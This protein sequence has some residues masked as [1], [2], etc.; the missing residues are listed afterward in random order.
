MI[1][2]ADFDD[3]VACFQRAALDDDLWPAAAKLVDECSGAMSSHVAVVHEGDWVVDEESQFG[4][5]YYRG[6]SWEEAERDFLEYWPIDPRKSR[7]L[8][9]PYGRQ[10]RNRDFFD[11]QERKTAPV[12]NEFLP[13]YGIG[14]QLLTRLEA[15]PGLD[16]VWVLSRHRTR[17]EW[18]TES[19]RLIERVSAHLIHAVAVRQELLA[20]RLLGHTLEEMLADGSPGVVYLDYRGAIAGS[21]ATAECMLRSRDALV[22]RCGQLRARH[23]DDDARLGELL[24][25]ALRRHVGGAPKGG[26]VAIRRQPCESPFAVH[27][28]PV[29]RVHAAFGT[30]RVAVLVLIVDPRM[31]L[32]IDPHQTAQLLGLT[33]AEGRVVARLAEGMSVRE[34]V[35]ASGR[36]ENTVRSHLKSALA[37]TGCSR[38]ADLV[39]L[40]FRARRPSVPGDGAPGSR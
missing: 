19:L 22:D 27:V 26:S 21:N 5:V 29:N 31:K 9:V 13:N 34:I 23:P 3:I 10:M 33:P 8:T 16:V 11:A 12:I 17:G 40:A 32:R 14:R 38:Q 36:T 4:R 35:E 18:E 6:E 25:S 20:A 28:M 24:N 7:A 37:K 2:Q 15:G 39:L 30:R 1:Q